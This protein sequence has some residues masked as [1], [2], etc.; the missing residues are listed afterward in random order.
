M[1]DIDFEWDESK[2]ASNLRK[3]KVS[4]RQATLAFYDPNMIDDYDGEH[5]EDEPR[6]N[7]IG[8][9]Q[10]KLLAVNFTER[11]NRIRIISARSATRK[12]HDDYHRQDSQE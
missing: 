7:V 8:T 2:A 9:V 6:F 12:E 5:S 11:H 3:H 1:R 10:G 4:F